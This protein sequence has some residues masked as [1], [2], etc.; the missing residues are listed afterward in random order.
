MELGLRCKLNTIKLEIIK[1]VYN[2]SLLLSFAFAVIGQPIRVVT[3]MKLLCADWV[4][5]NSNENYFRVLFFLNSDL[6]FFS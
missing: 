2:R 6:F 5:Q 3:K 1:P 4:I